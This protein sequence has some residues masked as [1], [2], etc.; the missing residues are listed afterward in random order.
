[1]VNRITGDSPIGT[2]PHFHHQKDFL[3]MVVGSDVK[4]L[5]VFLSRR[6]GGERALVFSPTPPPKKKTTTTTTTKKQ[7]NKQTVLEEQVSQSKVKQGKQV[8]QSTNQPPLLTPH[9][10]KR[11]RQFRAL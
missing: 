2:T 1:M 4:Q 9:T 5:A 6:W 8:H 3:I 7:Q 10:E 11:R